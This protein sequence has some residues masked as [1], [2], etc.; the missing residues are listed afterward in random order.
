[1]I[2]SLSDLIPGEHDALGQ[3]SPRACIITVE[4][5]QVHVGFFSDLQVAQM[6][7][8][9]FYLFAD[10]L[11]PAIEVGIVRLEAKYEVEASIAGKPLS[12]IAGNGG[13]GF[14][15]S[16]VAGVGADDEGGGGALKAGERSRDLPGRLWGR[17]SWRGS[18]TC[19]SRA[20]ERAADPD[21]GRAK[22]VSITDKGLK[23]LKG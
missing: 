8:V 6:L 16:F 17:W 11:L 4:G 23:K 5:W 21:D 20:R 18:A 22:V 1:M 2:L 10:E 15:F 7:M 19:K 3:H 14:T 9:L 13:N 12:G